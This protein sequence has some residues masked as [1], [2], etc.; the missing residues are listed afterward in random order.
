MKIVH[1]S[2]ECYPVAK[3]GG[4][5]DVVGALPK[6]LKKSGADALLVMPCYDTPFVKNNKWEVVFEEVLSLGY[7]N[8]NFQILKESTDVLGFQLFSVRIF[9]LIEGPTVYQGPGDTERFIGFQRAVLKWMCTWDKPATI[10]HCHDHHTGLVP[11]MMYNCHEYA[12]LK[13]IPTVFTIHNGLYQGQFDWSKNYL[14]PS[15][16]VWKWGVLDWNKDINPMAA[17]IKCA[18][19]FTT[20]STGY[21]QELMQQANGL[22]PLIRQ[23]EPKTLGIINGID[24]E[25]WNPETDKA[26]EFTYT[27]ANA[28]AKKA[29]NKKELCKHFDLN[30]DLPLISFIGR[31]VNEKGAD[32]LPE[33]IVRSISE[34]NGKVNFLVLGSG[35]DEIENKLNGIKNIAGGNFNCYIGYNENLSHQIYASSDFL[36][37]PSRL[38]PCGLNQL[39]A[40]RYGTI[41]MVNRVGGLKDTVIDYSISNGF[42]ITFDTADVNEIVNAAKR[43]VNLFNNK[44]LFGKLQKQVMKIEHSWLQS[45]KTYMDLY[46][47]LLDNE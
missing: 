30:P 18:W 17:G 22:E 14:L 4:L 26:L 15:Y 29:A 24:T 13:N 7:N 2:A 20:V 23:E 37:M 31:L 34:L 11:F 9:G 40:L 16:D 6:Y 12:V 3:V 5:G 46:K 36:I 27:A 1:L 41:P 8:Y 42:G 28:G 47:Q 32:L 44:E 35:A 38:E 43:A 19:K 10:V 33:A 21:L 25:V 45:A 39:Y